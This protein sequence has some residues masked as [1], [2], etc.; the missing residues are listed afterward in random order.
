MEVFLKK[1]N[2]C[3]SEKTTLNLVDTQDYLANN[4]IYLDELSKNDNLRSILTKIKVIKYRTNK[5]TNIEWLEYFPNVIELDCEDNKLDSDSLKSLKYALSLQ[6][7][8]ISHNNIDDLT[9]LKFVPNLRR[10]Y[11][12]NNKIKI[13]P[14]ISII[15]PR[16]QELHCSVN[17]F[18]YINV[19]DCTSLSCLNCSLN[20]IKE[21]ITYNTIK[22]K[23]LYCR[24]NQLTKLN[25]AE[26][27]A[28]KV[29]NCE[30]NYLTDLN[31]QNLT[32]LK[33][34]YCDFNKIAS[35]NINNCKSIELLS[36]NQN[37]LT[38]L[39]LRDLVH[40][41]YINCS[42]NKLIDINNLSNVKALQKLYCYSNQ[43]TSLDLSSCL[44]LRV[45][46][47]KN[48]E[49]SHN[50][51]LK[52]YKHLKLAIFEY[53]KISI[54]ASYSGPGSCNICLEVLELKVLELK[55]ENKSIITCCGHLFHKKCLDIWINRYTANCPYC[56][57]SFDIFEKSKK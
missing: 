51:I 42:L 37:Q 49:I 52:I 38:T 39:D 40:L 29:L 19:S 44:H 34:L 22:L 47:C 9:N 21:I 20:N 6:I 28:L 53:D 36:C 17:E 18:V 24:K 43:L 45:V 26:C 57:Q 12:S 1:F 27:K 8:F 14:N 32:N 16:L 23:I 31:L 2:T 3:M 30:Y 13:L 10:L 7:L 4:L 48:N 56:R 33:E 50:D 54:F 15:L 46:N 35:L 25:V 41:R 5:A 11:C 55:E